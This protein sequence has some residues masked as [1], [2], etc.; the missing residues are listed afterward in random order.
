MT[1][2]EV[3]RLLGVEP[4]VGSLRDVAGQLKGFTYS[5][6]DTDRF[7]AMCAAGPVREANRAYWF[8]MLERA[9]LG[10][11]SGLLRQQRWLEGAISAAAA[12]NFLA[13][14]AC[15][16]GF[17]ESSADIWD[18]LNG[19]PG[20][21]GAEFER[22]LLALEGGLD[23]PFVSQ[24]LEDRLVHFQFAR[25]PKSGEAP[26][27]QFRAKHVK[28]YLEQ[29]DHNG[30]GSVQ[31]CYAELCAV[32]HP[33]AES[34]LWF[35]LC[36]VHEAGAEYLLTNSPDDQAVR[37]FGDRFAKLPVWIVQQGVNIPM[38]T[39]KTLNEYAHPQL[40][41]PILDEVVMD[42]IPAWRRIK[43]DIERVKARRVH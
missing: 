42:H 38:L 29:L 5:F 23:H 26:P 9:H 24:G 34:L 10:A 12:P 35:T 40:R 3:I 33:G 18:G 31:Q 4:A 25:K 22:I 41:T 20:S 11:A 13:F 15:L 1:V 43:G 28:E 39:L 17:V 19:V 16:R 32:T 8:E 6:M 30:S 2:D 37:A 7:L 27:A 36:R 21:F 14:A